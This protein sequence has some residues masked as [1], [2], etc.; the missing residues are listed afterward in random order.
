MLDAVD[1]GLPA[2][3]ML[4]GGEWRGAISGARSNTLD[5]YAQRPWATVPD[6]SAADVDAAVAAARRAFDDGWATS[7][8][9]TR[10]ALL[11]RLGALIARDAER[12]AASKV[13]TTASC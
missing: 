7:T 9:R 11:R 1:S 13:G 10:A 6:A 5:P 12:L 2:Y 3:D 4:I 8:A